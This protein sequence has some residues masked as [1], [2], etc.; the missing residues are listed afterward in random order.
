MMPTGLTHSFR[1]TSYSEDVAWLVI[2]WMDAMHHLKSHRKPLLV[3]IYRELSFQ[4]SQVV[5]DSI[6]SIAGVNDGSARDEGGT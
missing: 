1:T 6:H 4:A 2:L 3:G 5:Q